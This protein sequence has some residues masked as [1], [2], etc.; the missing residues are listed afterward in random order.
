MPTWNLWHG[1][2]KLS[3]GCRHCYVFRTDS[4]YDRDAGQVRKTGQFDLPLRRNR[5]G[6]YKLMPE[7]GIVYTCFTSDFLLEDADGWRPDVGD[8]PPPAGSDVSLHHQTDPPPVCP[9]TGERDMT[10]SISA[11]RWRT[12]SG[13]RNGCRFS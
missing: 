6:S 10:T 2:H 3:P 12:S 7:D 1:C 4:R 5:Q 11:A 8:D 13:R 9:R